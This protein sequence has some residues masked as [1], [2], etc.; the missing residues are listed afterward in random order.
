VRGSKLTK[1]GHLACSRSG[2]VTRMSVVVP[3]VVRSIALAG[4]VIDFEEIPEFDVRDIWFLSMLVK[5]GAGRPRVRTGGKFVGAEGRASPAADLSGGKAHVGRGAS[6][7]W[8]GPSG[9]KSFVFEQGL[10]GVK[11]ARVWVRPP[12]SGQEANRTEPSVADRQRIVVGKSLWCSPPLSPD[13]AI[14]GG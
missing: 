5:A 14:R 2:P 4:H 10:G 11:K 12:L 7:L 8:S 1:R 9:F 13:R 6:V 3:R